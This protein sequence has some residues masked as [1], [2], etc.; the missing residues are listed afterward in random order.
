[1]MKEDMVAFRPLSEGDFPNLQRWLADPDVAAWW[2]ESD[3]SLTAIAAKYTPVIT[4]D[5]PVRGFVMVIEGQ[6]AGLIQAYALRDHPDYLAQVAVDPNAVATDLVIGEASRRD[7]GWGVIVL[8]AFLRRI[9]FGEMGA[10]IAKI[11]PEPVNA[12]A[13]LV[14]ERTGFRWVKTVPVIDEDDP[15]NTGEEYIMLLAREDF[16]PGAEG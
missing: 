3:L 15:G 5:D 6:D 10:E 14:Y 1:M 8:R 13:I 9:V 7:R 11:A 12:R 2:R 16:R 4:E